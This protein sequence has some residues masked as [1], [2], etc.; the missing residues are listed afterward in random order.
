MR[1]DKSEWGPNMLAMAMRQRDGRVRFIYRG[2]RISLLLLTLF[3]LFVF[4]F[5]KQQGAHFNDVDAILAI[6]AN[7]PFVPR[8]I[9]VPLLVIG[10]VFA[11][12][13]NMKV[14]FDFDRRRV[15][16]LKGFDFITRNVEHPF[17]AIGSIH[18]EEQGISL[19]PQSDNMRSKP[20]HAGWDVIM[21][22]RPGS[23]LPDLRFWRAAGKEQA[24][25][26]AGVLAGLIGCEVTEGTRNRLW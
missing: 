3:G 4:I 8:F 22:G 20:V 10:A 15:R 13:Y 19:V 7:L 21:K 18:M 26:I 2:W 12:M 25:R 24:V 5:G 23:G 17:D 14:E 11:F 1:I 6:L 9:I 16:T